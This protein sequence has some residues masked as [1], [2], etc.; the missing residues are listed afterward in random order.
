MERSEGRQRN[1]PHE[2]FCAL[3]NREFYSN[4]RN[5]I[6][7]KEKKERVYNQNELQRTKDLSWIVFLQSV[8]QKKRA[9]SCTNRVGEKKRKNQEPYV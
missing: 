3:G 9:V 6:H 5:W 7:Q 4:I 1:H 8:Q 2:V